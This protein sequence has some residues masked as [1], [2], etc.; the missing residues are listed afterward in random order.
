M[1][2]DNV[3]VNR[4][5]LWLGFLLITASVFA[6]GGFLHAKH[7]FFHL[8][9]DFNLEM[10]ASNEKRLKYEALNRQVN[11]SNAMVVFA[12]AGSLLAG[13]LSLVGRPCCSLTSR[14][15]S[16][17]VLGAIW[18]AT[19]GFFAIIAQPL[20]VPRGSIP[21][22]TTVGM[23]QA[24]AFGLLGGGIG[25]IFAMSSRNMNSILSNALKGILAGGLAGFLFP[26]IVGLF[27]TT[28]DSSVL[29]PKEYLALLLWIAIPFAT[30]FFM[31]TQF[32]THQSTKTPP[33]EPE[34]AV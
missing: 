22:A 18:G 29:I 31:M 33:N 25:L 21:S 32:R 2:N 11:A 26:V 34:V 5:N 16:G 7:P 15:L 8:P 17:L 9:S 30:I 24:L 12:I 10:G 13:C 3:V 23:S 6:L 14:I 28:Q 20:I 4:M 1:V 27:V 19:T